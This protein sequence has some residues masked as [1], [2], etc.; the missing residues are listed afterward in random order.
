MTLEIT[1]HCPL[2]EKPD[3]MNSSRVRLHVT[4]DLPHHHH[5]DD[6]GLLDVLCPAND[7]ALEVSEN[8]RDV[9]AGSALGVGEAWKVRAQGLR[10]SIESNGRLKFILRKCALLDI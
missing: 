10:M 5:D 3:V 9:A 4:P 2:C 7:L 8:V 1:C 6:H